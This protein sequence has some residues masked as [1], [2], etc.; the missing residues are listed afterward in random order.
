MPRTS[1]Q[2]FLPS[3][4]FR[5]HLINRPAA[6]QVPAAVR[7]GSI[8]DH[9]AAVVWSQAADRPTACRNDADAC[10][11]YLGSTSYP[12]ALRPSSIVARKVVPVPAHES[13]RVS[14]LNENIWVSLLGI[15]KGNGAG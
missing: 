12:A 13:R 15:S 14:S 10:S 7:R 3:S 6:R 8:S 9:L 11:K 5:R 2:D 1:A 4:A